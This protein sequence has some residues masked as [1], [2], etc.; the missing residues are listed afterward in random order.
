MAN[1]L[2]A[3]PAFQLSLETLPRFYRAEIEAS[4]AFKSS[5]LAY[6]QQLLEHLK[7]FPFGDQNRAVRISCLLGP[8]QGVLSKASRWCDLSCTVSEGLKPR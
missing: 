2:P 5:L 3:A 1:I 4:F 6:K 8:E 7:Y